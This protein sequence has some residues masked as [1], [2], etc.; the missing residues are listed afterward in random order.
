MD[1]TTKVKAI[2]AWQS[3]EHV[4]PLTCGVNSAHKKLVPEVDDE[5]IFLRCIDCGYSQTYIPKVIYE[6]YLTLS[7]I[8]NYCKF[9]NRECLGESC[10]MKGVNDK[11]FCVNRFE[12]Q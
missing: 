7:D 11:K 8:K 1:L 3:I 9:Y 2:E 4:H 6:W 10:P 12:I 5:Q